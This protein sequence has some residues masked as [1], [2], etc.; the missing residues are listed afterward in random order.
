M[1]MPIVHNLEKQYIGCNFAM[2][3]NYLKCRHVYAD[4]YT[5]NTFS[6]YNDSFKKIFIS[7]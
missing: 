4:V 2:F 5:F 7:L 3:N 1:F 6:L